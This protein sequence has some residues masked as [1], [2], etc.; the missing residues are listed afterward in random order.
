VALVAALWLI[1]LLTVVASGFAYSMRGEALAAR[2]AL[3]LAQARLAADGAVERVAFELGRPRNVANA[4]AWLPDGAV[5]E[6]QEGDVRLTAT[7][8]DEAARIDLNGAPE[9]LLK[10][11]FV[12]VGGVDA[13]AAQHLAEAIEDWRDADDLRRPNGAEV[14]DYR[15]AGRKYGPSNAPFTAVGELSRVLGTTPGLMAKVADTLTVYSWQAAINPA[16]AS[17]DVLLALPN[18]TPEI[19]DAYLAARADALANHLPPPPLPQA[20]G[21]AVGAAPVWRIRAEA[22]TPDGVTFVREAVLRPSG[23]PRRPIVALLWQEGEKLPPQQDAANGA[24]T[25][26]T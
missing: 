4:E 10:S 8:V 24:A 20:T 14:D 13:D 9:P 7:A 1:V 2:N 17:R 26:K 12:N 19:V 21:F 16:T 5:H 18:V 15:A 25:G 11:L 23:D 3:S 22:T 6:W